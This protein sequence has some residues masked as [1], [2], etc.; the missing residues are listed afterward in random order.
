[1]K[2]LLSGMWSWVV[3]LVLMGS[4]R[5]MGCLEEEKNAL[6]KIK[7]A[8]NHPDGSSLPSWQGEDGDCC[9][10]EGVECDNTTMQVTRL[11]LN[12][13]R[14]WGLP[15]PWVIDASLFLPLEELQVLNLRW[16]SLSELNGVLYL[17][18]LKRLYLSG[19]YLQRV[20]SLYKQT[21]VETQNLSS[22]QLEGVNLEVLDL[23]DNYLV[24][25]ALADITRITSLKALDISGC[26]LNASKLLEGLCGLRTLEELDIGKNGFWGPLP[27]CF[28]NLT[29]LRTLNVKGNNFS[30]AIPSCLLHN[31]KSLEYI[32]F[33]GNAFEGSLSLASLANTSNLEV[34]DL[35][36]NRNHLEINTE[37]PTWFASSQLKVFVLSNCVLNKDANGVIPSFFKQR[38]DLRRVRLSHSGMRGNFPN[39]LLDN[40]VNLEHLQLQGNNLSGALNLPSNL[41]LDSMRWFDV[42]ANI[43]EGELPSWIGFI[44]PNLAYL[45]FSANL[46]EGRIPSSMGN[47]KQL[48]TLDL[49]NNGFT[50]EIPKPL[51]E[52]S[53]S[54]G[55]LKLSGNNLQGQLPL[56]L[57]NLPGLTS[58][59]LDN[60]H[61]TGGI[62]HGKLNGS[63][64][65]VL[66]VSNNFLSGTLPN[67]IGD[68]EY[69]KMLVLSSNLL[70]GPLPLNFCNLH[71]LVLLDLSSNNLGPNIPPCANVTIMRFLHLANYTLEGYFPKFLS[72]ASSIVTLDLRHNALSGEVPS[73]IGLLQN[74]KVLLLQGNN[75]ESS[76]P[77]DL[78]LLKNMSILDLSQN[79]LS[80]QIPSC[81]EDLSFGKDGASMNAVE[82]SPWLLEDFAF[83][84]TETPP[85]LLAFYKYEGRFSFPYWDYLDYTRAKF[86]LEEVNFMTKRRLESY[87]GSILRLMS[88]MDL[89]Q[90]NL[91]G[92]IPPEF[93]H[94]SELRALNLSH[95]HLTGPIPDMFS[96]LKNVESLD[97][98]YNSLIGPIPPQLMELYAL[99][100]FR[101]AHNN[102]SGRIPDGKFQF[103]TFD[104]A[105]YEG[106]PLLCGTPL[107]SCDNSS[108]VPETPPSLNHTREDDSWREAFM[109]SF[110]GS[111]V[112][113]FLGVVLFLCLHPYY[114]YMLSELVRKLIPSF[115]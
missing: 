107:T 81:L 95:N 103:G 61:F 28:C 74:L 60:N 40:N 3:L 25:D 110:A 78:C 21:S 27:S 42:S 65:R 16:N 86:E 62:S 109:W 17:K 45:N 70:E 80:G 71:H 22:I 108:Q 14:E 24:N 41:N 35:M 9:G 113:A 54:L 50:G 75:F 105:S 96:N 7:A 89:S 85:W 82:S 52:N 11:Y 104:K 18:K 8:F 26:E 32:G 90:N 4:G 31:L 67:W 29:S 12:N 48:Q 39:W 58:L 94:L 43:I 1:M 2:C 34:F 63:S 37:G 87:K 99:S 83:A 44:L 88:G 10:W 59:Y 91:T 57:F 84:P 92:F 77:S 30:G 49:S 15:S 23:Y 47:M 64:L 76:I 13:T 20:P 46:L 68:I 100:D 33:S 115:P 38:R 79:N 93:G 55:L 69:L 36:D 56:R 66:D 97:L 5:S 102:L 112:V 111:Y 6:L 72:R 106:N 98:S 73:W 19:N 53:T 51:A 114:R 101:V